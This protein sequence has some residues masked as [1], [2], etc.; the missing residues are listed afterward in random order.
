MKRL[1]QWR[2]NEVEPEAD[3]AASGHSEEGPR[4]REAAR[5]EQQHWLEALDDRQD[6]RLELALRGCH[7]AVTPAPQ[8]ITSD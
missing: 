5:P 4:W 3:T 1:S 2:A 6:W 8:A 7:E